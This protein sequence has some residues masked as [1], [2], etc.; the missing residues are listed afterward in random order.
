MQ[1]VKIYLA[2]CQ[3]EGYRTA[4]PNVNIFAAVFVQ[5]QGL[6]VHDTMRGPAGNWSRTTHKNDHL[7]H[8]SHLRVVVDPELTGLR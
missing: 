7:S 8:F 4:H 1:L 5:A 2:V 3:L 6:V